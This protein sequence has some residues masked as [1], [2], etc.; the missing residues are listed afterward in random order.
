MN[1]R[2]PGMCKRSLQVCKTLRWN[3]LHATPSRPLVTLQSE[4]FVKMNAKI[5]KYHRSTDKLR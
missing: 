3:C 4:I 2:L 1:S 5:E